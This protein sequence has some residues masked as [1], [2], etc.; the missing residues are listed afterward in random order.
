[1]KLVENILIFFHLELVTFLLINK[2]NPNLIIHLNQVDLM[3]NYTT[4]LN[5]HKTKIIRDKKIYCIFPFLI[6]LELESDLWKIT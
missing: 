4:C 3:W 2:A 6:L 5:I 1:M